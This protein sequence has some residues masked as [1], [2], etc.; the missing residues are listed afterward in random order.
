MVDRLSGKGQPV[1]AK[2]K[3]QKKER[4]TSEEIV[5]VHVNPET[6]EETE[7]RHALIV[8]SKTGSHIIP[9]KGD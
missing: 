2:D 3:W 4:V 1:L 8:Y 6:L 9:R 5:G 7:T